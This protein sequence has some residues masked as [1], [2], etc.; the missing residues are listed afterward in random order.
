MQIHDRLVIVIGVISYLYQ[1]FA[2]VAL[3][4]TEITFQN[5]KQTLT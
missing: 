5:F 1:A 2:E 3:T 4:C